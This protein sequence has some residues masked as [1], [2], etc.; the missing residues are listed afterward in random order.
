MLRRVRMPSIAFVVARS[1]PQNVIGCDNRLPWR[2]RTDL[3]FFKAVTHG[4]AVIMG[5]K[6]FDSIRKPLDGRTNI[7]L[8]RQPGRDAVDLFWASSQEEALLIADFHAILASRTMLM[9]VGGAEIYRM[10]SGLAT[11]IFL[12]EVL[13][14]FDGGEAFFPD[15]FDPR[16]WSAPAWRDYPASEQDEYPFRITVLERRSRTVRRRDPLEFLA[17]DRRVTD[18]A[19]AE[20]LQKAPAFESLPDEPFELPVG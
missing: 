4:H 12:T 10:F 17:L 16:E 20:V 1:V 13:H 8:S 14:S 5:R 9:V 3:R 15:E 18:R 7:V 11:T 6:T 2:L 19:R